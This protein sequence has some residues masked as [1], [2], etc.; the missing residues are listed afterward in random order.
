M[1]EPRAP[2]WAIKRDG[3]RVPFE[4]DKICRALFATGE[5]LG[6]PDAF[7]ARELADGV[8]YFLAAESAGEAPTTEAIAEV[9]VKVVRE[10]GQPALAEAFAAGAEQR[11]LAPDGEALVGAN[12]EVVLRFDAGRPFRKVLAECASAYTLQAV[13]ARDLVAAHADGL[14]VLTGLEAPGELAGCV[15]GP[16]RAGVD[17]SAALEEA[18]AVAGDFLALDGPEYLL[19]EG[20][21]PRELASEVALGLR[22]TGARAV[23]NLNAEPAP[24]WASALAQGP[25]FGARG[26]GAQGG[27]RA[28]A[29]FDEL[30]ALPAGRWRIDWHLGGR[31]FEAGGRERLL[32]VVRRALEGTAIGFAFDR[33]RRPMALAEGLDRRAPAVLLTVGLNL[34]ALAA[35]PGPGGGTERF[36]QR[37]GS[38][39]RLALS[40]AVQKR[41]FLRRLDRER[42]AGAPLVTSGFLLDRARLVV[43]PLGLDEVVKA[44][45]GRGLAQGGEALDFGKQVVQRMRDVLRQDGLATRMDTCV[46]GPFDFR[47]GETVAGLTPWEETAPAK[48]QLRAAGALHGAAEHGTAALFLPEGTTA[49]M[50]EEWLRGAWRQTDAVRVRLVRPERRQGELTF[51]GTQG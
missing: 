1:S 8:T 23:V 17:L 14:V 51:G 29:L 26:E 15:V 31:D 25:L 24:S 21:T 44:F 46:D 43:A 13:F 16:P 7:L 40:A 48:A 9:V 34:P 37:L 47:L 5:G 45:V 49:E 28:E 18:R 35:Q 27:E 4:A 33:P 36:L 12:R 39:A 6:R 10:L 50:V 2:E 20:R 41:Q 42:P 30:L 32:R 38:L 11:R 19:G 3:R 22:A